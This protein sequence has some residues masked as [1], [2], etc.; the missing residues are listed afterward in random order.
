VKVLITF[1]LVDIILNLGDS[2]VTIGNRDIDMNTPV[3]APDQLLDKIAIM[4]AIAAIESRCRE[5]VGF[6]MV[7][8]LTNFLEAYPY[9]TIKS[10]IINHF[11]TVKF[12]TYD[13]NFF[14]YIINF[15]RT[16]MHC[17]RLFQLE[18]IML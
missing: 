8:S 18:I 11:S 7:G 12:K 17:K 10:Q 4:E 2:D 15:D 1:L 5:E 6:A 16:F 13:D 9:A 14:S 3:N